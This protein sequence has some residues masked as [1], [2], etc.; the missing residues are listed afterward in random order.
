MW[1]SPAVQSSVTYELPDTADDFMLMHQ[2][3]AEAIRKGAPLICPGD[4]GVREVELANALLVSGVKRKWVSTP[5]APKEFDAVLAKL[6]EVKKLDAAKAY[7]RRASRRVRRAVLRRPCRC[8]T[9]RRFPA[10]R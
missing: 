1:N 8:A 2:N 7:F 5:A 3:F 4:E 9:A 6:L 10:C